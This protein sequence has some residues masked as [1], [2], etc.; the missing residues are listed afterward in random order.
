VADLI[1]ILVLMA[2]PAIIL[3]IF[4][5]LNLRDARSNPPNPRTATD[6]V[7]MPTET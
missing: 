6:C 5:Y 3:S 4:R 2:V 1:Q 7:S